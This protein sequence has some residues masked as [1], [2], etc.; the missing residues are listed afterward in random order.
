VTARD[1]Y[2]HWAPTYDEDTARLG[3]VAPAELIA[4]ASAHVAPA[5][6]QS[7]VDLGVGTGQASAPWRD[8]GARVIGVD[9]SQAMLEQAARGDGRFFALVEHDLDCGLPESVL[10]HGGVDLILSCGALHFVRD[11]AALLRAARAVLVPAGVVAFTYI[12]EQGRSFGPHTRVH[13]TAEVGDW[14]EQAGMRVLEHREFIAYH[15]DDGPVRYA[16]A[17]ARDARE[18]VA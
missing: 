18:P 3:W 10:R 5:S 6:W 14:L 16:L 12:P 17:V 8:A 7:V 4:A 9:V 13:A 15:G 11:L 1:Q 2:E